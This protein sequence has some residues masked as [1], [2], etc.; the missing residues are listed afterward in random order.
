MARDPFEKYATAT[1]EAYARGM[2]CPASAFDGHQLTIV[3][4]PESSAWSTMIGVTFGTSTVLSIDPA[5]REFAEANR[6]GKHY[7]ALAMAFL[8]KIVAEG[9][10]RGHVL[11]AYSPSLCFTIASEPPDLPPPGGFSIERR[12]AAWMNAEQA[13]SRF[14][15]GVGEPGRDG[16][17]FRNRYALVLLDQAGEPAAVAGAFDTYSMIEIGVDVV[18]GHRGLGLGRTV[19]GA[20]AREIMRDGGVPFYGC[21]ATNIRSHRTAE[22]CGFRIVCSDVSVSLPLEATESTGGA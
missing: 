14:E 13:N 1:R 3:D 12:D 9:A 4:R 16:R 10:R 17:E 18:R 19:V 7:R 21:G 11:A 20:L 22:S 6:P 8:D 2:N 15:N 5:Y